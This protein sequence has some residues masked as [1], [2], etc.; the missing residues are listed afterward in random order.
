MLAARGEWL[1]LGP[2]EVVVRQGDPADGFYVLA[3]GHAQVLTDGTSTATLGAGDH[4]GEI[5][6]LR[7]VPRTATVRTTTPVRLFRIDAEAFRTLIAHAFQR[8]RPADAS[9]V[10]TGAH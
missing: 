5:A 9:R 8:G 7:D 4:F 2:D 1:R 6:L 10:A 3:A